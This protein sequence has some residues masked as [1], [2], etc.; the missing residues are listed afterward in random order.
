LTWPSFEQQAQ[1]TPFSGPD[2]SVLL[3]GDRCGV[4]VVGAVVVVVMVVLVG[5]LLVAGPLCTD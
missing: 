2:S 1:S 3:A 5:V 4:E